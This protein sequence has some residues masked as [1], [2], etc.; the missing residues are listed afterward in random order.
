[1]PDI[2]IVDAHV[3]LWD[4]SKLNYPWI[5]GI[6]ALNRSFLVEDYGKATEAIQ[7]EAMV[8]MQSDAEPSQSMEEA[9]WVVGLARRE[10]RIK[11]IIPAAALEGGEKCR[12]FLEELKS[13]P[14]VKGIRRLIQTE[15]DP[16]FCL[17]PDFLRGVQILA[18]Y[19]LSFDICIA[20]SQMAN[21]IKM[22]RQCPDVTFILDHIAKPNIKD[23]VLEPW[24]SELKAFS[25]I[26]NVYCKI[27][28]M[29]TEANHENWTKEDLKPYIEHVVDCFGFDRVMFGGDWPVVTL[30]GKYMDWIEAL[31]WAFVGCSSDELQKLF[32]DNAKRIYKI[33]KG[34]GDETKG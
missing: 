20:H 22:A 24:T 17:Q 10:P 9:M 27:S 21:T 23:H 29:V 7:V 25:E 26:A 32:H 16:E 11:A 3:H 34:S 33:V 2:Q 19:N 6:P 18:D 5:D 4:T 30:A 12:P 14:L 8:F 31:D 1:M 13:S 28:G 15:P